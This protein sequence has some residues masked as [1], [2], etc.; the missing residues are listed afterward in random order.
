MTACLR[1]NTYTTEDCETRGLIMEVLIGIIILILSTIV[2][3]YFSRKNI[4][5]EVDRLDLWKVEIMNRPVTDEMAKVKGLIMMGQTEELFER[6]RKEW[7]D[8]V[9]SELPRVEELLFDAEEYADKYR[10][11]KAKEVI[12]DVE[13]I[14]AKVDQNIQQILT[15]L[16]ELVESE[17]KNR[18]EIE[19]LK[20]IFKNAK[21]T[22]LVHRHTFGNAIVSLEGQIEEVNGLLTAYENETNQGNYLAAREI[23]LTIKQKLEHLCSLLENIPQLLLEIQSNIPA[24]LQEIQEG[25]QEM[26]AKGYVLD[27][28]H[29]EHELTVIREKLTQYL[30]MIEKTDIGPVKDGVEEIKERIDMIYDLLEKEVLASQFNQKE[31]ANIEKAL[32]MLAEENEKT[33]EETSFVLETYQLPEE[34]LEKHR[35]IDKKISLLLKKFNHVQAKLAEDHVAH[36]LIKEEL[37]QISEQMNEVKEQY[38]EYRE[39]LQTLRK[40]ELLAREKLMELKKML[41]EAKWLIHKSNLPGLPR[42]FQYMLTEAKDCLHEAALKLEE[43]PLNMAAVNN[44]LDKAVEHVTRATEQ[45]KEIVEQAYLAEKVIQYGNRYRSRN[46]HLADQLEM[47]EKSFRSYDYS[48]ALEEAAAAIEEVEPGALKRIQQ[49]LDEKNES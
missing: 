16:K 37:E 3:G 47:A 14:L 26:N 10:F 13:S 22:L 7:D 23:V 25:F 21:K 9:T 5:N 49:L 36:S 34:E 31:S 12:K 2:F 15:E 40:D 45:T 1:T 39:M 29:A 35:Q 19:E 43:K 30:H 8:I 18:T 4:Y 46:R 42:E 48:K 11:K 44:V 24:Q 28:I 41:S 6:W 17:E 33:K 20:K 38:A 32:Q 27:H